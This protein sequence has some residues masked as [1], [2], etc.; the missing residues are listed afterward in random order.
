LVTQRI[1]ELT[2]IVVLC[3]WIITGFNAIIT[4]DYEGFQITTPVTII[5]VGWVCSRDFVARRKGTDSG[6]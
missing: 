5:A 2:V 6:S 1:V 4:K 3:M